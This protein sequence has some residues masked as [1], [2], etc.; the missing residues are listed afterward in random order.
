MKRGENSCNRARKHDL[1]WPMF[2]DE[3]SEANFDATGDVV[4]SGFARQFDNIAALIREANG[5]A[6]GDFFPLKTMLFVGF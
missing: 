3:V 2:F 5:F 6:G 4:N 1:I